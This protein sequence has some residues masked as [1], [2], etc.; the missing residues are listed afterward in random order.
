V[1][2]P[3]G[4]VIASLLNHRLI[5]ANPSGSSG[6]HRYIPEFQLMDGCLNEAAGL[7]W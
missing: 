6:P 2:T 4:G 5:A 3:S 7:F 1:V